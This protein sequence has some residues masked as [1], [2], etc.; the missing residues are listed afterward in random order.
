MTHFLVP[1]PPDSFRLIINLKRL[2]KFLPS[3]AYFKMETTNSILTIIT[4]D[5]YMAN[6]DIKDA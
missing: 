3:F 4:P 2:I 6:V 1:K 5:C